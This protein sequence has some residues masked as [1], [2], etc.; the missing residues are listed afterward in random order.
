[1]Q[2]LE[3]LAPQSIQV[4]GDK[5]SKLNYPESGGAPEVQVKLHEC[6]DLA[7]HPVIC[8][9][10]APILLWLATP[11]GKRIQSTANWPEFRAK[12]F[13][14]LKSSLQKKH[15]GFNWR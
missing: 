3:E 5:K 10:K 11:E 9:G 2:W 6:F 1:V 4:L 13:P 7:E 12:E 15:P 8:E 14:K